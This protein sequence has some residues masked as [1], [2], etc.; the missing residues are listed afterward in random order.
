MIGRGRRGRRKRRDYNEGEHI[1][2][3]RWD[4]ETSRKDKG[5]VRKESVEGTV[6]NRKGKKKVKRGQ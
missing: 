1:E 3:S 5:T 4:E 2:T 6:N